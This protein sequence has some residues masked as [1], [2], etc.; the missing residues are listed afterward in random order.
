MLASRM[1]DA[2]QV[3]LLDASRA[4]VLSQRDVADLVGVSRST[5]QRLTAGRARLSHRQLSVLAKATF[6][7]DQALAARAASLA[8]TTLE[9]LG[10]V[11]PRPPPETVA[12]PPG[13][14]LGPHVADSVLC[15][16][17]EAMKVPPQD[18]RPILR[19]A[20]ARARDLG[21]TVEMVAEAFERV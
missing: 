7:K 4:L 12:A 5:V 2:H 8:G 3:L 14:S 11:A 20:F 9:A 21:L 10:L 16:A 1:A 13:A 18:V 17:A 15:A 19:A 6:P